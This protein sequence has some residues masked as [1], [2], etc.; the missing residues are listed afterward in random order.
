M[1]VMLSFGKKKNPSIKMRKCILYVQYVNKCYEFKIN[2]PSIT[3]K[4]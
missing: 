2:F 1:L 4:I 3:M